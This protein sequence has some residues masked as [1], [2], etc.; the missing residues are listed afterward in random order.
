[1]ADT[2]LNILDK[3]YVALGDDASAD[4]VFS[5]RLVLQ[6][7]NGALGVLASK[8]I[9]GS[10]WH[11]SAITLASG[12]TQYEYTP[13]AHTDSA[14]LLTTLRGVGHVQRGSDSE[15][16]RVIPPD[17]L[18]AMLRGATTPT[19]P[20]THCAFYVSAE[21]NSVETTGTNVVKVWVYP[22]PTAT[23]T[24]NFKIGTTQSMRFAFTRP[25]DVVALADG[26][27]RALV[28][29]V[30]AELVARA[31]PDKLERLG[32]N[33]KWAETALASAGALITDES[34][35]LYGLQLADDIVQVER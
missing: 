35:R 9:T 14:L 13:P 12:D 34:Q 22:E 2:I 8:G 21:K 3:V 30:A 7:I 1:M 19:G 24:L 10:Y 27:E 18:L 26:A 4:P 11:T 28:L 6:S 32:L 29:L 20:V 16:V 17:I 31:T 23:E 15:P 25:T 5:P 33:P